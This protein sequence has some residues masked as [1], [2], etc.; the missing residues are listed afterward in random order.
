MASRARS[1]GHN[2]ANERSPE[3]FQPLLTIYVF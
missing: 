3:I 2:R 1:I